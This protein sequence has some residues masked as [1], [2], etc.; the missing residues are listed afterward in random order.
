MKENYE[1]MK[2]Y[3]YLCMANVIACYVAYF[4]VPLPFWRKQKKVTL[5]YKYDADRF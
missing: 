2:N 1:K 4:H 3:N 5:P